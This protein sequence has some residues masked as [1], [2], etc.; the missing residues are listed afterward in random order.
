MKI[1]HVS[2]YTEIPSGSTRTN[3]ETKKET[4]NMKTAGTTRR[5]VCNVE[6]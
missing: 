5:A 1:S 2:P 3:N 6:L 4:K